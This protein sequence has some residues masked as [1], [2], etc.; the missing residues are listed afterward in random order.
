MINTGCICQHDVN[1]RRGSTWLKATALKGLSG[2]AQ[3]KYGPVFDILIPTYAAIAASFSVPQRSAV[4]ADLGEYAINR[5][6]NGVNQL[7]LVYF[8]LGADGVWRLD[9]M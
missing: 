7:F 2:F 5:T 1:V 8:V 6:I 4:T 9:S 3:S